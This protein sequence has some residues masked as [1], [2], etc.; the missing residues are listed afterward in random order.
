MA[1]L[2]GINISALQAF[3]AAISVTSNNIANANTPNYAQESVDLA[4]AA[5][6]SNGTATVGAGVVVAGISRAYNQLAETQLISSQSSLGQLNSLQSYTNQIDNLIGTTGGGLTTAL[7]GYYNA[8]STLAN[9]PTSTAARQALLSQAKGVASSFQNTAAQLQGLNSG[10]NTGITADVAQINSLATSIAAINTK[11]ANSQGSGTASGSNTLLDQRDAFVS[12]LSKLTGIS[13]TTDPNGELNVFVGTGIPLVLDSAVTTLTTT[14]N[15]FNASQLEVATANTPSQV[16]SSQFT[17]GDLGGLLAARNQA[18]NPVLNQLGQIATALTQSANAQQNAGLDLSGQFGANLFSVANPQAI[19][20]SNNLG[21]GK[22]T[23]S[24]NN[25][26]ALTTNDYLLTYQSGAYS[27]TNASTGAAVALTSTGTPAAPV[28]TAD[29]LTISLTGTPKNGDQF[30]IQPTAGAASSF[31]VVLQNSSQ[32][33]AG[34]ALLTA[35]SSGN[36]GSGTIGAASVVNAADPNLFTTSTISFTDATHYT[37]NGTGSN[38][39]S[40][41]TAITVNGA[42][43]AISGTPAAGDTFTLQK[44]STGDNRNA[45]AS[46]AQQ[47]QGVLNNKTVSING[48]IDAVVTG[49]GSQAQQVNTAQAAQAA[50]NTQAD[51]QVQSISGVNLDEQAAKLLQ[52]QQAYQASAQALSIAKG[53]FTYFLSSINGTYS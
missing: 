20:S 47:N 11:L 4:S 16:L 38:V 9:N 53:L 14:S 21:T 42:S 8:W 23:V 2:F 12:S 30:L 35:A 15:P 6:Q 32:L 1:D 41:G 46:A 10:I 3:Q 18:V 49:F 34:G 13:T 31:S 45:L 19:A 28:F 50:V 26:G 24:I 52:W 43:F 40:A 5:P 17:S 48:A 51:Q 7:Q 22:A 37:I 27:L 29:G 39:Y 44:S 25:T 36:K 33:A